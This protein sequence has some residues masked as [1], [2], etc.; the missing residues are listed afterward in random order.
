MTQQ[1]QKMIREMA[2]K[3]EQTLKSPADDKL[4]AMSMALPKRFITPDLLTTPIIAQSSGVSKIAAGLAL[5]ELKK[6]KF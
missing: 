4:D 2:E 1:T 5:G 3:S 6:S